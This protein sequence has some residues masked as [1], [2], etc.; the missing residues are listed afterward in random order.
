MRFCSWHI[1][2]CLLVVFN[3]FC[4][5]ILPLLFIIVFWWFSIV[6]QFVSFPHLCV[7]FMTKFYTF[8]CFHNSRCNFSTSRSRTLL[9]ISCGARQWLR[10][11]FS[12]YLSV[13]DFISFSFKKESFAGYN[14]LAVFFLSA[15][16]MYYSIFS[17]TW[18][19]NFLLRNLLWVWWEFFGFFFVVCLFVCCIGEW[20]TLLTIYR[21]ICLWL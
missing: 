19:I 7:H 17:L 10:I 8:M 2:N 4:S 16:G 21:I 13:K 9:S 3:T 5:F 18:P 15:I 14:I 6:V 12:F 11:F 20:M 1:F